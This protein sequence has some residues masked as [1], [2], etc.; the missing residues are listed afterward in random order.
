METKDDYRDR[1]QIYRALYENSNRRHFLGEAVAAEG[2]LCRLEGAVFVYD[3][4]ST[5][6]IKTPETRTTIVDLG[7]S[8]YIVN[9]IDPAVN[10]DDVTYQYVRDFGLIATDND[11]SMLNMNEFGARS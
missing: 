1:Q 5:M 3:P 7:E 8:G 11:K 9:V 10:S 6:Y 4:K 2:A